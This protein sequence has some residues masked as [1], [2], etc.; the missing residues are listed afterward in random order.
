[1]LK[2]TI[3]P[4]KL[5]DAELEF[6]LRSFDDTIRCFKRGKINSY[7]VI[8]INWFR[9][10]CKNFYLF[11]HPSNYTS[12]AF[13]QLPNGFSILTLAKELSLSRL[14]K[15][16][17]YGELYYINIW[18]KTGVVGTL[19]NLLKLIDTYSSSI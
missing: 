10:G 3:E 15:T 16:T 2:T 14:H 18:C 11:Q 8:E 4:C 9:P 19:V 13:P 1:M 6:E 17:K 7:S 12:L 5:T